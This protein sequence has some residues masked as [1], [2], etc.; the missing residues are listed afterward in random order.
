VREPRSGLRG[1]HGRLHHGGP[2]CPPRLRGARRAPVAPDLG[3]TPAG[4]AHP[5]GDVFHAS[6]RLERL[7]SLSTGSALHQ[8]PKPEIYDSRRTPGSSTTA[9]PRGRTHSARCGPTSSKGARPTRP[10]RTWTRRRARNSGLSA[11]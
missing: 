8:A 6:F 9:S 5:V 11:T 7:A 2:G 4:A 1:A 10:P 3:G